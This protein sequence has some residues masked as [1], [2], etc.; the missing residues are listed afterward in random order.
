M[1]RGSFGS[2]RAYIC[3]SA[4]AGISDSFGIEVAKLAGI[5]S[6]V[7]QKSREILE[8][9]ENEEISTSQPNLFSAPRVVEKVIE[10]QLESEIEQMLG[11]IDPDTLTPK[12]ALDAMYELQKKL[13]ENN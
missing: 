10:L 11:A 1:L 12:E 9:L 5:P 13:R 6:S 3:S 2:L 8:K 7:I 4:A